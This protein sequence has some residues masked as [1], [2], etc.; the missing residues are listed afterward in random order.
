M[1]IISILFFIN[2]NLI[3]RKDKWCPKENL[4]SWES[5]LETSQNY[6]NPH[7]TLPPNIQS[8]YKFCSSPRIKILWLLGFDRTLR[9]TMQYSNE[10]LTFF[11]ALSSL[12]GSKRKVMNWGPQLLKIQ[13]WSISWVR[14]T[15]KVFHTPPQIQGSLPWSITLFPK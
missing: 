5:E 7:S 3:F 9:R 15:K 10:A 11:L 12:P 6:K 1:A 14:V 13:G 2:L 4:P 8:F